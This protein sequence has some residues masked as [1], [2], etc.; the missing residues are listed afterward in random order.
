M[1]PGGQV[2]EREHLINLFRPYSSPN[3]HASLFFR[4]SPQTRPPPRG[5]GGG[6]LIRTGT[7]PRRANGCSPREERSACAC[8][9]VRGRE[10]SSKNGFISVQKCESTLATL[11]HRHRGAINACAKRTVFSRHTP[12]MPS[13]PWGW[14]AMEALKWKLHQ[15][16]PRT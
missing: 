9:S 14:V 7:N 1:A 13:P 16:S 15:F 11:A 8:W 12:V 10:K 4:P 6:G 5:C 3:S 2:T